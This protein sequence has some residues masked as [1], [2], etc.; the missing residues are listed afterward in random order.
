MSSFRILNRTINVNEPIIVRSKTEIAAEAQDWAARATSLRIVDRESCINASTLLR[1]IKT[2]RA[3]ITAF[4]TPHID[5]AMETKRK[6]EVSRKA[7]ADERDRMDAPLVEA[8]IRLKRGLVAY[9]TEQER[10]RLDRERALQ[11][12]AQ[13]QAEALTLDVAAALERDAIASGNAEMLAEAHDILAQPVEAAVVVVEST[14]P[15]VQGVSYRDNWKVAEPVDIK[16]LATAVGS[17]AVPAAFLIPNMMALNQLARAT[18][19]MQEI[20]GVRFYN[21]RQIVARG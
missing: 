4:W 12:E 1:S 7:L 18:K 10:T 17:G 13:R 15:K 5:A 20:S 14:V 3:G 11:A 16:A 9:E 6:A 2:L 19:G 8:E 21:D